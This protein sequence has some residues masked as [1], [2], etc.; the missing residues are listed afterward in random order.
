MCTSVTSCLWEWGE[1]VRQCHKLPVGV[2][3]SVPQ[4]HKLPVG[5]G[6]SVNQCY[7]FRYRPCGMGEDY[8]LIYNFHSS[9]RTSQ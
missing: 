9:Q 4:C 2:G 5:V 8:S 3:E 6:E 1:S 7:K